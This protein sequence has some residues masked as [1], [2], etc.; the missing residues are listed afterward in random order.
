MNKTKSLKFKIL[1]PISVFAIL[2]GAGALTYNLMHHQAAADSKKIATFAFDDSKAPGWYTSGPI[3]STDQANSKPSDPTTTM[4]VGQGTKDN[5]GG[6]CFVEF[7][8]YGNNSTDPDTALNNMISGSN[9]STLTLNQINSLPQ[10]MKTAKG[11]VSYQLYQYNQTGSDSSQFSNGIELGYF[12]AGT[13]YIDARGYCK[14]DDELSVT[15]P[16]FSAVS[17]KL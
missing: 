16:V 17:F 5:P 10:E 13:G 9:T 4:I 8:Y 12:R 2:L 11:N 7:F 3:D 6:D 14:T 15:L 1:V